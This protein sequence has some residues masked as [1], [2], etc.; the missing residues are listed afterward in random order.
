MISKMSGNR[1][2]I[3]NDGGDDAE[4]NGKRRNKVMK[5]MDRMYGRALAACLY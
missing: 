4:K 5:K 3:S 2:K 1:E